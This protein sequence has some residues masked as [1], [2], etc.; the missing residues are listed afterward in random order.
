MRT[1]NASHYMENVL[2]E[3]QKIGRLVSV[4]CF[5]NKCQSLYGQCLTQKGANRLFGSGW[6]LEFCLSKA[7]LFLFH[8]NR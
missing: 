8:K 4:S 2:H 7:V 6:A 5:N 3:D 1:I